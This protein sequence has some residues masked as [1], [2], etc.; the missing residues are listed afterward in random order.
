LSDDDDDHVP[1]GY[2]KA[3]KWKKPRLKKE[4]KVVEKKIDELKWDLYEKKGIM[5]NIIKKI[6]EFR[7][8]YPE[9]RFEEQ[10]FAIEF[11][12]LLDRNSHLTN[13]IGK[14]SDDLNKEISVLYFLE[15]IRRT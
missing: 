5:K 2:E 8:N 1:P 4:I 6:D 7:D 14:I 15:N 11:F 13:D 12:S 3:H 10:V 9:E